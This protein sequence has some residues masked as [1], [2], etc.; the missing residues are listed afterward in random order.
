MAKY[1]ALLKSSEICIAKRAIKCAFNKKHV[2]KKGDIYLLIKSSTIKFPFSL[3][4]KYC[5]QCAT[6]ILND[7]EMNLKSIIAVRIE[8]QGKI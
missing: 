6:H 4:K 3:E 2:M 5:N 8:L 7:A 1:P